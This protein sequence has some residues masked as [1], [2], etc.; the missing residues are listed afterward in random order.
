MTSSLAADVARKIAAI[1]IRRSAMRAA[2][3][4]HR[5]MPKNV[6][7][8]ISDI[9]PINQ[10]WT[11]QRATH[12]GLDR[13][14]DVFAAV[15][16]YLQGLDLGRGGPLRVL[17]FG[18]STGEECFTL[19]G[20]FPGAKVFGC[21][22]NDEAL[23]TAV[24][25]QEEGGVTFFRS[26]SDALARHGPYD[27]VFCM[28]SLCLF[29]DANR[30]SGE[31][32]RFPLSKF[33]TLL[34]EIDRNLIPGGLLIVFN[35]SYPFRFSNVAARYDAI[36]TGSVINN[37]FVNKLKRDGRPFTLVETKSQISC[38]RMLSSPDEFVDDDFIS[39]LFRKQGGAPPLQ[40][41]PSKLAF[42]LA[43]A[44]LLASYN[45]SDEDVFDYSPGLLTSPLYT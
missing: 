34:T 29:P 21:D 41:T 19:L 35:S 36:Q 5:I 42:Y 22:I 15:S 11:A 17:S 40:I 39:C 10:K 31:R 7:S 32:G 8:R 25:R 24:R 28:S 26:S 3:Y 6:S 37:G 9:L 12:T 14:P 13:Y 18:C 44:K 23:T 45:V 20:Y 16:D 30:R 1:A 4:L 38:H 27:V 2:K 33:N 43:D